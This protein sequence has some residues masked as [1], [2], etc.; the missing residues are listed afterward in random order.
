VRRTTIVDGTSNTILLGEGTTDVPTD[1]STEIW[2]DGSVRFIGDGRSNTIT[3]GEIGGLTYA[4]L[5]DVSIIAV[6]EPSTWALALAGFAGLGVAGLGRARK[7]TPARLSSVSHFAAKSDRRA[8]SR[9]PADGSERQRRRSGR[10]GT[11]D[12]GSRSGV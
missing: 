6:P 9:L 10:W 4:G 3:F 11:T 1:P 2:E 8:A 5:D 12:R 7:L